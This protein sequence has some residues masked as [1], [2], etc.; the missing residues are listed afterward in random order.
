VI[1][2][3]DAPQEALFRPKYGRGDIVFR[4][5]GAYRIKTLSPPEGECTTSAGELMERALREPVASATLEDLA[6]GARRVVISIPDGRRPPIAR[7]VLPAIIARLVASGVDLA[8]VAIFIASGAHTPGP[9]E[10]PRQLVGDGVPSEIAIVRNYSR[11]ASDFKL[12]GITHRGTPVMINNLLL[13]ADLNIVISGVAFHYFAGVSGGRKMVLPGACH[14]ETIKAN[15]RLTIDRD[16]DLD[17][18][19]RSGNLDGNP[20]HEDMVEGMSHLGNVFMINMVL[21]GWGRVR[22]VTCGDGVAS[23]LEAAK[24]VRAL[25]EVSVA[26]RCDLAVAG[27]GGYPFDVDL[28]QTHKAIDHA[29]HSVR[30]GGALVV[31]ASCSAGVGSESFLP[32]FDLGGIKAATKKLLRDYTLN[33]QTALALMKKLQRIRIILVSSLDRALVERTGMTFAA[34]PAEALTK[35]ETVVGSGPLTYIFPTASGI[36]PVVEG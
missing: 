20:V 18:S 17:P 13:Q 5:S 8:G 30:D 4:L 32:W 26:A 28:I 1:S 2:T 33:G 36:L 7:E 6:R 23:H 21:D 12:V 11:R 29:A 3:E 25:L 31:A 34:D 16:G 14:V 35:A 22:D 19:C 9:D 24:R 15:H 27:A 10:D